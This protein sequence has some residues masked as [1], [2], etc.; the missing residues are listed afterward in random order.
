MQHLIKL[1]NLQGFFQTKMVKLTLLRLP[2][3]S[4]PKQR[5][6]ILMLCSK[7]LKTHSN[8]METLHFNDILR[9]K[10]WK[11]KHLK[12]LVKIPKRFTQFPLRWVC[13]IQRNG[14]CVDS[15]E[16]FTR[17]LMDSSFHWKLSSKVYL[18]NL[19]CLECND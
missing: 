1:L 14:N 16:I 4:N 5:K 13:Q 17:F 10:H 18:L 9:S 8:A 11:F 6:K 3:F 12:K 19:K 15:F 7:P 2:Y